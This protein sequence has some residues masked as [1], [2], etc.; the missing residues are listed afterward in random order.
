[1]RSSK[2][3]YRKKAVSITHSQC[4]IVDLGI[5]HAMRMRYIILSSAAC[6]ALLHIIS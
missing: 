3:C 1:M 5:Q 4:V 2:H 6:L